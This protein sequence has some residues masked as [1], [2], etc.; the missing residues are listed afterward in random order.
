M[1]WLKDSIS[2]THFVSVLRES[3]DELKKSIG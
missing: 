3:I 2:W 1:G